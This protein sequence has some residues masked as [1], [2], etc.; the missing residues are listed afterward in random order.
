MIIS[1][2]LARCRRSLVVIPLV[3][4]CSST[5]WTAHANLGRA[6]NS[7]QGDTAFES[8]P[9]RQPP[10][11]LPSDRKDVRRQFADGRHEKPFGT[12]RVRK[13]R[14]HF[15]TQRFVAA[16]RRRDERRSV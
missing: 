9:L 14:L 15:S 8:R 7:V 2:S 11:T 10:L 12:F 1:T 3:A 13:Q 6:C 16:A 4:V 5:H